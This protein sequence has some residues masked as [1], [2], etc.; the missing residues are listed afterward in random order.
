[1]TNRTPLPREE[2]LQHTPAGVPDHLLKTIPDALA[3]LGKAS[4]LAGGGVKN[5]FQKRAASG[6]VVACLSSNPA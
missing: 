6:K 2:R 4:F 5:P 1:M 3:R